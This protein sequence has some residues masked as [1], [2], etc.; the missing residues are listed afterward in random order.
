MKYLLLG[1]VTM[2]F[3]CTTPSTTAPTVITDED[4][5]L[6][7]AFKTVSW[8]K[9]YGEQDTVLLD[10]LLHD[11]F[12]MIDDNGDIYTKADELA[13]VANYGPSYDEFDFEITRLDIFENGTAI[14]SGVGTMK[15][16]EAGVPGQ[17]GQ[18]YITKY[19]SSN[20]LIKVDGKWRAISSHVS[21]VK[22]EKFPMAPTE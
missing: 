14:I 6:L 13:Y 5:A 16:V 15:G 17:P 18:A 2:M 1:L 12:Q 19:K 21:G 9:A 3:S 4:E 11:D 20:V 8:P 10:E 22:E 7:R